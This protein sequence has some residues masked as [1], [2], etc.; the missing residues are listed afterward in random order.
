MRRS[1][2]GFAG[3]RL[4]N[5]SFCVKITHLDIPGVVMAISPVN[6]YRQ[7]YN[8]Y[9]SPSTDQVTMQEKAEALKPKSERC[10]T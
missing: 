3:I 7:D 5:R 6:S 9:T 8:P 4:H 10:E 2:A 1:T